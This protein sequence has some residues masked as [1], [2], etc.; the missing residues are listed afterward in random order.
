MLK[1]SHFLCKKFTWL[2]SLAKSIKRTLSLFQ[3][4]KRL[5][6]ELSSLQNKLS[7]KINEKNELVKIYKNISGEE[8][9]ECSFIEIVIK[10]VNYFENII[11]LM[12]GHVYWMGKNNTYL[13]CNEEHAKSAELSSQ[14]EIVGRTNYDLPWAYNAENLHELNNKVMKTG[15][16]YT[17]EEPAILANN[18]EAL[19]LTK[20]TPLRNSKGQIIGVLGISFDITERKKAKEMLEESKDQLEKALKKANEIKTQFITNME[21]DLRTPASG[22]ASLTE[23]LML[24]EVDETKKSDLALVANAGKQLLKVLND[25][26]EFNHISSDAFPKFK[27]KF[28]LRNLILSI[29]DLEQPAAKVKNLAVEVIVSKNLDFHVFGDEFRLNRILVN[30]ISNAI[31]FTSTGFVRI[32]AEFLE[33]KTDREIILKLSIEDSGLGIPQAKLDLIYEK[34]FRI[35]P[36]NQGIY[37][38]SGLGLHIVKK[39]IDEM[40]GQI[41]AHSELNRGTKFTFTIP[42]E[43]SFSNGFGDERKLSAKNGMLPQTNLT[44]ANELTIL[45]VEDDIIAQTISSGILRDH[46]RYKVDVAETGGKAIDLV[47]RNY[48]DLILM[49]LGLPD[50]SGIEITKK[51]RTYAYYRDTPIIALSAHN[52]EYTNEL[53]KEVMNDS[54]IKPLNIEKMGKILSKWID[55]TAISNSSKEEFTNGNKSQEELTNNKVID[56]K[57]GIKLVNGKEDLA[58]EMLDMLIDELPDTVDKLQRSFKSQDFKILEEVV[59]KLHGGSSYCGVPRLKRAAQILEAALNVKSS[60]KDIGE[61]Y[62]KLL[63]EINILQ[64]EFKLIY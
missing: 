33:E 60:K 47:S 17:A 56:L 2:G 53:C 41:T 8:D 55:Q 38:G 13:G 16:I 23:M 14:K 19:F 30:L 7:S 35:T 18:R 36:S 62:Q 45:L 25:I 34:F 32:E 1:F 46:F 48:Y 9:R 43:L 64:Q 29:I 54:I 21:H 11:S 51:I 40:G 58:K 57:L 42:F 50:K 10:I 12:P 37:S 39:F 49:D 20:K 6:K 59:H 27:K 63:K 15:K 52:K 44:S 3:E 22:M 31:K 4:N 26:L 61:C 5:K 24:K 28:N